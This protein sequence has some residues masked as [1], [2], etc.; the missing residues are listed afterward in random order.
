V[1]PDLFFDPAP[2]AEAV[3]KAVCAGCEVRAACCQWATAEGIT[4]GVF[5]GLTAKERRQVASRSVEPGQSLTA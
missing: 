3:A 4:E 1:G 2:E 5:G